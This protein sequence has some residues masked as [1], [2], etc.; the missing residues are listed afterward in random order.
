MKP[1]T[2][3]VHKPFDVSLKWLLE[4]D[5]ACW[6]RLLGATDF[7]EVTVVD[8]DL[9]TVVVSADK[10]LRIKA[11]HEWLLHSEFQSSYDSEGDWR[12]L[13][14][15]VLLTR[16][17][18]LP[19]ETVVVLLR[20]EADGPAFSGLLTGNSV[21]DSE[22]SLLFRYRVVRLWELPVE[23]FLQGGIATLPLAPLARVSDEQ[24]PKVI[25]AMSKRVA[26]ET[27][28][29]E[30][31]D[32]WASTYLLLGLRKKPIE[33][34]E[35]LR[36]IAAMR[37]S[38]TYQAILEEGRQEGWQKGRQEGSANEARRMLLRWGRRRF[39]EPTAEVTSIIE[40]I[41]DV[42]VIEELSDHIS[43]VASWSDLLGSIPVV[44][45]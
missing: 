15:K 5:P 17:E 22:Q 35:L 45:R 36:G 8:S 31:G 34:A 7:E 20:P 25:E 16:R 27:S 39:G 2:S 29:A 19:V 4:R 3:T 41:N 26:S 12:L 11:S 1:P 42:E 13:E 38:S 9:S 24:L 44:T 32:L 33:I 40:A 6:A 30:Q 23:T 43:D 18:K 28:Q 14:Y 21:L 37:E 10:V